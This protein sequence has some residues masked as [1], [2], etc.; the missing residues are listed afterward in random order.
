[1]IGEPSS[2]ITLPERKIGLFANGP[3]LLSV[4]LLM[5]LLLR[6]LGFEIV[7]FGEPGVPAPGAVPV[8]AEPPAGGV[9][10]F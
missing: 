2:N 8:P 5:G 10:P 3:S 1:L 9:F 6:P 7:P 4:G